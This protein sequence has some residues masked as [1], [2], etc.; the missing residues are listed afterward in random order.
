MNAVLAFEDGSVYR[1]KAFG[2]TKTAVGE[3]VFNTAVMGYQEALTDPS[4]YKNIL[5]M[6]FVEI[7]CYG[8]NDEDSESS[9]VQVAGLVVAQECEVPSNWRCTKT[10]DA[11]LKENNVPAI[12]GVDT[13]AITLKLRDCGA[14]KACLSTENISDEEAV[15]LAKGWEGLD[16]V[17]S[18]KDVSCKEAYN[19]DASLLKPFEVSGVHISKKTRKSPTFKCAAIDFGAK[20]S[21]LESLAFSGFDVKVF[22]SSV[23]VEEIE[24][25]APDGIF[26]S[27]G[28]GDPVGVK[29]ASDVVAALAKKYP[30]FAVGIGMQI[31]AI[32]FGAKTIRLPFGHHGGNHPVKN[33][34]TDKV[35]ITSQ[36]NLYSVDVESLNSTDLEL[37]EVNLNDNTVA[38]FKHKSLPAFAI[39]YHP[40]SAMGITSENYPFDLFYD[41]IKASK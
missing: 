6:T 12:S 26:L 27:T 19:L 15:A 4:N 3:A 10:L 17:D 24:A 16:G 7:G 2:A 11:F 21:L 13:R 33:L 39:Q 29:G 36:N 18:A 28:A 22:P 35:K 14:M 37:T 40:E 20:K 31:L 8:I 23:S 30:T 41:M 1:G 5:T 25:F 32:A 38:G 9:A 34:A